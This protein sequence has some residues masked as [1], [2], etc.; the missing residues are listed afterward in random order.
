VAGPGDVLIVRRD[1]QILEATIHSLATDDSVFVVFANDP[2]HERV[3][4]SG[5]SVLAILLN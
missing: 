1:G 2:A 5:E 3:I 4:I